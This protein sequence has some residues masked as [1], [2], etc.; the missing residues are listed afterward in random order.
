MT[1][2]TMSSCKFVFDTTK[3]NKLSD[4]ITSL[5]TQSQPVFTVK[6]VQRKEYCKSFH[7]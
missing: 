3:H 2:Q 6:A 7:S 4:C 5:T 1:A